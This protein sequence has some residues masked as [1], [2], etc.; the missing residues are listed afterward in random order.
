M[1]CLDYNREG[2]IFSPDKGHVKHSEGG[3]RPNRRET[4][5]VL[6]QQFREYGRDWT[7]EER[8]GRTAAR[9][10]RQLPRMQN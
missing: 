7:T 10:K 5:R 3:E 4:K 9:L 1:S 6:V 8:L 2:K